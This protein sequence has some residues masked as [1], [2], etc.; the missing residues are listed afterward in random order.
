MNQ[1]EDTSVPKRE[2]QLFTFKILLGKL[3]C[4]KTQI[5]VKIICQMSGSCIFGKCLAAIALAKVYQSYM[6]NVFKRR[7]NYF[8]K[9]RQHDNE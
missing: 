7:S 3:L 2:P 4:T 9:R 8:F 5:F 1:A 6:P